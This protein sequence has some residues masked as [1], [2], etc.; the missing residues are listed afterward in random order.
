MAA[1][2]A[3]ME[4]NS[5]L[6]VASG[7][8]LIVCA[9]NTCKKA[10]ARSHT[11]ICTHHHHYHH[12]LVAVQEVAEIEQAEEKALMEKKYRRHVHRRKSQCLERCGGLRGLT[13]SAN[14]A[15]IATRL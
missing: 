8:L 11:Y 9:L 7:E 13:N 1:L 3:G 15:D 10:P 14:Q 6:Y 2:D 12:H 4:R 5:D